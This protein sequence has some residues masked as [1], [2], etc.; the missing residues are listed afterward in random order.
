MQAR[1]EIKTEW[2]EGAGAEAQDGVI[3]T[4]TGAETQMDEKKP[5][6]HRT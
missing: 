4:A 5:A 1:K 6:V 2:W 3:R